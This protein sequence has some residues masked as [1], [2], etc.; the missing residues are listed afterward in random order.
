MHMRLGGVVFVTWTPHRCPCVAV[1]GFF[2]YGCVFHNEARR[3]AW[4]PLFSF[5]GR[6][7]EQHI[8]R[9]EGFGPTA[10]VENN[11]I[12]KGFRSGPSDT[13]KN[14]KVSWRPGGQLSRRRCLSLSFVSTWF[15]VRDLYRNLF[16]H[17]CCSTAFTTCS[18][19]LRRLA[20]P[21]C[22][23]HGAAAAQRQIAGGD[24]RGFEEPRCSWRQCS[25]R[26]P[27]P[28]HR[29]PR[30]D[31]R[32]GCPPRAAVRGRAR[33][34]AHASAGATIAAGARSARKPRDT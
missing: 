12:Q 33:T 21:C 31:A 17:H 32:L 8:C 27:P 25:H 13:S 3:H 15:A 10:S 29:C 30:C 14:K 6:R 28:R 9:E 18:G 11:V 23:V 1:F 34:G 16:H 4:L 7:T 2:Q 24:R 5:E 20:P 26:P 22:A 19:E